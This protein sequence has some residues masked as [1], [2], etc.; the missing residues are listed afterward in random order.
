[1]IYVAGAINILQLRIWRQLF[2][3][4]GVIRI[5]SASV[6]E[7]KEILAALFVDYDA[8][9]IVL[10]DHHFILRLELYVVLGVQILL[11]MRPI[12]ILLTLMHE[13]FTAALNILSSAFL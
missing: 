7:L 10:S 5:N 8:D 11:A 4:V 3:W 13:A 2:Y 9:I 1:M 6:L 12:L